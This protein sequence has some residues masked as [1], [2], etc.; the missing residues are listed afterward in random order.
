MRRLLATPVAKG[1]SQQ[2][3]S[4]T[5]WVLIPFATAN[6]VC[7]GSVF[8]WSLFN[9]PLMRLNGVVAPA[10]SDWTL[11]DSTTT[12]SL[13]MGGFAWGFVFSRYLDQ[14]GPRTC[15]LL[16]A[17]SLGGGF[18]LAALAVH[19]H[20][21]PLL[22]LGGGVWGLANGWAYMPPVS[23]LM[24]WFP[25]RK[26]F[27]SGLVLVGYGSG[28][29]LVAPV[30]QHLLER[31][32]VAPKYLGKLEDVQVM[33]KDGK[34][35]AFPPSTGEKEGLVEVVVATLADCKATFGGTIDPGVYQV[36]TGSTGVMESFALLGTA[37]S[38][39]MVLSAL[40]ARSPPPTLFAS[41]DCTTT[42]SPAS[43]PVLSISEATT[44]KQFALLYGGFV[45]ASTGAY[46]LISCSKL[47]FST[48]FNDLSAEQLTLFVAGTSVA[49]LS[50]RLVYTNAS[51]FLALRTTKEN[52]F[53]GRRQV[54]SFM[55][56]VASPLGYLGILSAMHQTQLPDS[57]RIALFSL[58]TGLCLSSFGGS[59]ANRPAIVSDLFGVPLTSAISARQLSGVL[60]AAMSGPM[61]FSYFSKQSTNE[62]IHSLLELVEPQPFSQ[63]FGGATLDQAQLLIDNKTLT[64]SRLLEICPP[65]TID[66]SAL[67]FDKALGVAAGLSI[68]ALLLNRMTVPLVSKL[69]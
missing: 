29:L 27:A 15:Q 67:V 54:Y 51:D 16:G 62:H 41:N 59:A 22:W 30:F 40:A 1:P 33:G 24:K 39:I 23:N 45:C 53:F 14:F 64:I 60:P 2:L 56:G 68:V 25:N 18:S 42:M 9:Q 4:R 46:G 65:G 12:F 5:R 32:R 17:A 69:T 28:A 6:H 50:G 36:G 26:G 44:T 34:L 11:G 38:T 43:L 37:F 35:F 8:A 21:L 31:Y 20:S 49:N 52:P 57:M 7:L 58:S 66:P 19:E 55:W 61:L 47:L 13:V 3:L 48:C 10:A 63:H